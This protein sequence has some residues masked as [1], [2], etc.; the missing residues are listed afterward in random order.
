[1]I[2]YG[3]C[4]EINYLCEHFYKIVNNNKVNI[5]WI[6]SQMIVDQH[7]MITL[8]MQCKTYF[9]GGAVMLKGCVICE[10]WHLT[11]KKQNREV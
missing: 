11:K 9:F 4:P 1:M 5:V 10:L 3:A 7:C 8:E 6:C 2:S